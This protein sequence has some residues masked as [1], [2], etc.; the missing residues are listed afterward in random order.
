[1]CNIQ[2][3]FDLR[4]KDH[5]V[6]FLLEQNLN[7]FYYIQCDRYAAVNLLYSESEQVSGKKMYGL[8][9]IFVTRE[10]ATEISLAMY[11]KYGKEDLRCY[12]SDF[13]E[14]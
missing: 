11:E 1:M 2:I 8:I 13:A 6:D 14:L 12:I 7:D 10:Y 9:S 4:L 5:I 3:Y